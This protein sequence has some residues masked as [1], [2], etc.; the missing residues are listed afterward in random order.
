MKIRSWTGLSSLVTNQSLWSAV[1]HRLV[2]CSLW[3]INH[4]HK[5]SHAHT[6]YL[7]LVERGLPQILLMRFEMS[8]AHMAGLPTRQLPWGCRPSGPKIHPYNST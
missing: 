2:C 6:E 8:Y 3:T 5:L 1:W 7:F 4:K